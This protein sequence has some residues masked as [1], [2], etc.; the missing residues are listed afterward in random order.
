MGCGGASARSESRHGRDR[1]RARKEQLEADNG[2]D[3]RRR[4]G[5]IVWSV[6]HGLAP[7]ILQE[8][9]PRPAKGERAGR[10]RRRMCRSQSVPRAT[11]F[12]WSRHPNAA[13]SDW[14]RALA[15]AAARRGVSGV[16]PIGRWRRPRHCRLSPPVEVSTLSARLART[17]RV[18]WPMMKIIAC[19]VVIATLMAASPAPSSADSQWYDTSK[20]RDL[21]GY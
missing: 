4:L 5:R 19:L 6:Q 9:R 12:R 14:G 21:W 16:S 15:C 13:S 2:G 17:D 18:R 7:R 3:L 1:D 8:E 20:R 11:P 10:G